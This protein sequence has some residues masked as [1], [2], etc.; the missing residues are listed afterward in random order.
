MI[1]PILYDC[2]G[3]PITVGCRLVYPRRTG[4]NMWLE[5]ITVASIRY[6]RNHVI[7]NGVTVNGRRRYTK[8]YRNCA[9]IP[10]EE[11]WTIK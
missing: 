1:I 6:L 4:S 9:V 7:I 2:V 8:N 11:Y 5:A 10:S 3:A